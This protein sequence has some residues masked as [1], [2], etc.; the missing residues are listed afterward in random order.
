MDGRDTDTLAAVAAAARERGARTVLVVGQ[1]AADGLA[2][3]ERLTAAAA[4]MGLLVAAVAPEALIEPPPEGDGAPLTL[5]PGPALG[6][7][8]AG[9][10]PSWQVRLDGALLTVR[11]RVTRRAE[12]ARAVRLL[13]DLG[14]EP[15]GVLWDDAGLP[16]VEDWTGDLWERGSAW[17]RRP[18]GRWSLAILA[19]ALLGMIGGTV[20]R[21]VVDVQEAE[22]ARLE[23]VAERRQRLGRAVTRRSLADCVARAGCPGPAPEPVD[24]QLA[25]GVSRSVAAAYCVDRGMRL[26]T[27]PE[28][29]RLQRRGGPLRVEWSSEDREGGAVVVR[30]DA[31]E[32][33]L[34]AEPNEDVGFRC[35]PLEGISKALGP[36]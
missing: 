18:A 15:L 29:R 11:R 13:R 19:L 3:V 35:V 20:A 32:T 2:W 7:A 21:R 25:L 31:E 24:D 36:E 23:A 34:A 22:E 6:Q 16:A 1:S 14:L 9:L 17:A 10:H 28:A 8:L 33:H 12:L 27:V 4:Q 26:P 30:G 5:V